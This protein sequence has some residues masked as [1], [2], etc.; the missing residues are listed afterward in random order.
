M[1]DIVGLPRGF[2]DSNRSAIIYLSGKYVNS[3]PVAGIDA[4]IN[5]VEF[6]GYGT[7]SDSTA[8]PILIT[9]FNQIPLDFVGGI[10]DCP[11]RNGPFVGSRYHL[12]V[13]RS[14]KDGCESRS[15]IAIGTVPIAIIQ[16]SDRTATP[17]TIRY[18]T[19]TRSWAPNIA[20]TR[21]SDPPRRVGQRIS[22]RIIRVISE[23][24]TKR[25]I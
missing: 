25:I 5:S 15:A 16:Y 19:C 20:G 8:K 14:L 24:K 18:G 3:R 10:I 2:R 6:I 11:N 13:A 1:I 4:E 9:L 22:K 7:A 21:S 17:S 23:C 12:C